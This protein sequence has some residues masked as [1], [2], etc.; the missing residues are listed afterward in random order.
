[1]SAQRGEEEK[2]E[3]HRGNNKAAGPPVMSATLML[4]AMGWKRSGSGAPIPP[5]LPAEEFLLLEP[6]ERCKSVQGWKNRGP[7]SFNNGGRARR[8]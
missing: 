5:G 1:M 4:Q 3:K 2:H 6:S 8:G 7:G